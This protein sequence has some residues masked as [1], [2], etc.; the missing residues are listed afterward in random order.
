MNMD[1][2]WLEIMLVILPA[3]VKSY[4]VQPKWKPN[5]NEKHHIL[6]WS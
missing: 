5:N 1:K 3:N 6:T 2:N 4:R